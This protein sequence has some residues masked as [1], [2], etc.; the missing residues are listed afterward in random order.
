MT[1]YQ[2]AGVDTDLE[3]VFAQ[4]CKD[5]IAKAWPEAAI[6]DYAGNIP[7]PDECRN[8]KGSVDGSGTFFHLASRAGAWHALGQKPTVASAMDVFVAG[9]P[10]VTIE[11]ILDMEVLRPDEHIGVIDGVITACKALGCHLIGGETAVLPGT[12]V[13]DR[14]VNI[15]LA[16]IGAPVPKFLARPPQVGDAIYGWI[17]TNPGVNGLSLIR[18][19]FKI[20]GGSQRAMQRLNRKRKE[21]GGKSLADILFEDT[22]VFAQDILAE[23][24]HGHYFAAHCNV[25]GHGIPGNLPR[26]LSDGVKA[27][28]DQHS[29]PRPPIFKLIQDAGDVPIEGKGGM[30]W[31]FHNGPQ[32]ISILARGLAEPYENGFHSRH[33]TC[34]GTIE[35]R[36][37]DEPQVKFINDY[38][39]SPDI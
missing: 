28:I 4:M 12:Y 32:I 2:A 19:I 34:I 24:E 18:K 11:D 31:T 22:P 37:G 38:R 29:W 13:D 25:T 35:K 36:H 33:I 6:G 16:V 10:P 17:S 21:L 3:A 9:A 1:T 7:V 15:N 26:V 27:V 23:M 8:M 20:D 14:F 39:D 5:R 30:Q